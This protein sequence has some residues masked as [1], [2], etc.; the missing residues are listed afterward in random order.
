MRALVHR[1]VPQTD[2]VEA[3]HQGT[4]LVLG[5][6]LTG[7]FCA[8]YAVLDVIVGSWVGTLV[9]GAAAVLY[10][11]LPPLFR[12]TGSVSLVA[13]SFLGLGTTIIVAN[14]H[15]AGGA[16]VLAWLAAVPIAAVLIAG[17]WPASFWAT[18]SIGLAV[19]FALLEG[20]GYTYPV[21]L[22]AAEVPL[23]AASVRGGLPLLV[24]LL[25]LVFCDERAKSLDTIQE[26]HAALQAALDELERAQGRLVQQEKLAA[27]GQVTAGIAH[28]IKNPLNFVTNFSSLNGE[29]ADELA[30]ALA[31]G[32]AAEAADLATDIRENA[33]RVH[34]HGQRADAIVRSMLAMARKEAGPRRRVGLNALV[35]D[36]VREAVADAGP[37]PPVALDEA[38]DGLIGTVD[39]APEEVGRAV[40]NVVA[41]AVDAARGSAPRLGGPPRVAVETAAVDGRVLVRVRDNGP[42]MAPDVRDRVFEPFFTTKPTG[43]GTGLGLALTHDIVVERHAGAISVESV[44]GEGTMVTLSLPVALPPR[45][46][47]PPRAPAD[48][49]APAGSPR[50]SAVA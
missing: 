21:S 9:M 48:A 1:L 20:A 38:Y 12:H 10:F 43:E 19:L 29:L 4:L 7:L 36:A 39:V 11:V 50:P 33:R 26:R 32:D 34:E 25:A 44:E 28:E 27:L 3:Y 37:R 6:F 17:G 49:P 5:S 30:A 46:P 13:N 16:E 22:T 35:A 41:N 45:G 8:G 23:W 18:V 40:R 2:D 42:G 15:L 24:Y 47:A 31:A 14:A